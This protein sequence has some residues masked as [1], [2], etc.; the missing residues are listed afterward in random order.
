MLQGLDFGVHLK[1]LTNWL[2]HA[3]AHTLQNPNPKSSWDQFAAFE[4][5]P[6]ALFYCVEI[7]LASATLCNYIHYTIYNLWDSTNNL[8]DLEIELG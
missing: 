2:A 4:P 5:F 6:I 3:V 7:G 8:T 1:F